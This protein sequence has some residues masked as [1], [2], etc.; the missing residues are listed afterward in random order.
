V[1]ITFLR[2]YFGIK[3]KEV[4]VRDHYLII[5]RNRSLHGTE[6]LQVPL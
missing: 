4:G 2:A 6:V 5:A 3:M 1:Q